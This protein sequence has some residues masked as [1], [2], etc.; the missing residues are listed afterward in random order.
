L[1]LRMSVAESAHLIG[2]TH[3]A[4]CPSWSAG[5]ASAQL[6]AE[7]EHRQGK[8]MKKSLVVAAIVAA[9]VLPTMPAGA[10]D[11]KTMAKAAEA[12]PA[13]CYFLPLLPKCIDA[14]KAEMAAMKH[15]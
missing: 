6:A 12:V 14:W 3:G 11:M 1:V 13:Y 5:L 2:F 8:S 4:D 10:A 15:K 7:R 9:S